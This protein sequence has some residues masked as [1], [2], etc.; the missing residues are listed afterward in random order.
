L[1]HIHF[2]LGLN[3]VKAM[4]RNGTEFLYLRH[5]FPCLQMPRYERVYSPVQT[6]V[7][8][9]VTRYMNASLRVMSREHGMPSERWLQA[10]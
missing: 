2:K 10:S 8:F 4:D 3:F 7:Y 9:F 6:F 5:K 1:P